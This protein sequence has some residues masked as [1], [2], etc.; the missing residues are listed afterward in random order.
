MSKRILFVDDEQNILMGLER[1]LRPMRTQ[2]EMEFVPSGDEAL[3]AFAEHSFNAVVTDMR[4]PGMTGAQLLDK[5]RDQFPQTIRIVL[6]GQSDREAMVRSISS[7]HQFLSKPCDTEQLK[8]VLERTIALTDL[9]ENQSIKQ[10]IF[11]LKNIPSLPTL[12]E[13]LVKE[14][15]LDS[16]SASRLGAI[17]SQDMAM[18]AKLLQM[19]NCPVYSTGVEVLEPDRA[20]LLLGVETIQAM[21]LSLSIF[22]ACDPHVLNAQA[23]GSLWEHSTF[24]SRLSTLIAKSEGVAARELGAYQSA[25]LLH[26][27]GKLVMASADPKEYRM[28][29]AL[30]FAGRDQCRLETEALGCSHAEVG[31]YLLGLW[32]LPS[33]IIEAVAW[34]HHPSDSP[35]K[36]FSPLAAVHAASAFHARLH[37]HFKHWD[38]DLDQSFL[39]RIGLTERQEIWMQLCSEEFAEAQPA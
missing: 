3:R 38:P 6:S 13:D 35:V 12:Y 14:L 20:V 29:E 11:R 28:I 2:W 7:A 19:V 32:G 30:G 16:P 9:L 25:G 26:N 1:T 27:I 5:I 34:H 23:A 24:V 37:P 17:I 10:F 21:V 33:S 4:M 15:R 39:E 36:R 8:S 31:A 18:T 22:S